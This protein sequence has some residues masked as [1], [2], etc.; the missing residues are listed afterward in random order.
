MLT[1]CQSERMTLN[2][3]ASRT[4]D[5][6]IKDCNCFTNL[7][8]GNG[9]SFCQYF[10]GENRKGIIHQNKTKLLVWKWYYHELFVCEVQPNTK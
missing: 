5:F 6:I 1:L 9:H 8:K 3:Y 4:V 2:H 10:H 7:R